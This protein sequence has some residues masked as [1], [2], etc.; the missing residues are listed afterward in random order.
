ML[1]QKKLELSVF[2]V[3]EAFRSTPPQLIPGLR[4]RQ[5]WRCMICQGL[6]LGVTLIRELL[7]NATQV[8]KQ[9]A[10]QRTKEYGQQDL[11]KAGGCYDYPAPD[12][13]PDFVKQYSAYY[14]TKRGYHKR[15]VNS[16]VG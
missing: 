12:D 4:P 8:K 1:I 11:A 16:N 15:S 5:Q 3:G 2:V 14:K 9:I 6:V 10:E 13:Q 7:K